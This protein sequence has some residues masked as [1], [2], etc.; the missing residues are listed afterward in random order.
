MYKIPSRKQSDSKRLFLSYRKYP[1]L[2]VQL[3]I[4]VNLFSSNSPSKQM[5]TLDQEEGLQPTQ[6][7]RNPFYPQNTSFSLAFKSLI[8]LLLLLLFIFALAHL[9]ISMIITLTCI[10]LEDKPHE[11]NLIECKEKAINPLF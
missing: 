5:D 3:N 11:A 10:N 2:N 9:N 1:I 7:E 6:K 4:N 8:I